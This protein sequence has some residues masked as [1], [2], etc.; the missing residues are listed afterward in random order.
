[1]GTPARRAAR[2]VEGLWALLHDHREALDTAQG[3]RP[4]VAG[5]GEAGAWVAG[6][7]AGVEVQ[8]A[9]ACR[10]R[11][12]RVWRHLGRKGRWAWLD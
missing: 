2:E 1:M 7:V 9:A 10:A 5:A 6:V 11:F 4:A 8:R 3:L 12:P